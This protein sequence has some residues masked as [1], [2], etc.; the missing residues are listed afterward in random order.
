MKRVIAFIMAAVCIFAFVGCK[1]N[2]KKAVCENYEIG[3]DRFPSL[4]FVLGERELKDCKTDKDGTMHYTYKTDEAGYMDIYEYMT[5][6]IDN[7]GGVVT[8]ALNEGEE[9]RCEL[10][11]ESDES[12][13]AV[14][15]GF[16]YKSDEYS[17]TIKRIA[18][19]IQKSE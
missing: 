8:S 17:L 10:A 3:P 5:Y 6:L 1:K 14:T 19:K 15:V 13:Y 12:G 4:E 7:C 9:G 16:D 11:M 18:G 2:E